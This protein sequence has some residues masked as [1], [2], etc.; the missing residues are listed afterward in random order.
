MG[1][2]LERSADRRAARRKA[3]AQHVWDVLVRHAGVARSLR[4]HQAA[5]PAVIATVGSGASSALTT[6]AFSVFHCPRMRGLQGITARMSIEPRLETLLV[7]RQL[8]HLRSCAQ[9][10]EC[11]HYLSP[12]TNNA[13]AHRLGL[14]FA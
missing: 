4:L 14:S 8:H 9:L 3:R 6:L 13:V 1:Q 5:S 2:A 11:F 12:G 10:A 7:D